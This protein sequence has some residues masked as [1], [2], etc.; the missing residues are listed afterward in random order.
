MKA[1]ILAGGLGLRLRP[2]TEKVPKV[3]V[4][5]KGKPLSQHQIE[6]LA[7][8]GVKDIIFACGYR[9]EKIKEFFGDGSSFNVDIYYS[10]EEEKLGT[11]GG[12]KKA[13]KS[14]PSN[15]YLVL[16]GDVITNLDLNDF[17]SFHRKRKLEVTMLLVPLISPY[18]IVEVSDDGVV[19][20]FQEK[21]KLP[22]WIN[23]GVYLINNSIV[24]KLPDKGD[25]EKET[26]PKIRIN[27]YMFSGYW[28]AIDTM[29]DLL[30]G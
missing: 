2:L 5:Y 23:G 19:V 12:I 20:G 26:F 25:I 28:K 27:G 17:I 14:F 11:G 1:I 18:G 22:Y 29:K 16:N 9:W 21:P 4:Q 3:L 10:V 7:G 15:E 24:D 13:M 6:Y 30:E 8:Y